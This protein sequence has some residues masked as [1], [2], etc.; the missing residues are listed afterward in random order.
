[1]ARLPHY[2]VTFSGILGTVSSPL[3]TWS[4]GL[5]TATPDGFGDFVPQAYADGCRDAYVAGIDPLMP[6]DVLLRQTRVA[7]IDDTGKYMV[8][9]DGAYMMA[10]NTSGAG[11]SGAPRAL[12]A[13]AALAVTLTTARS[14]P[15]GK[16]RIFLPFP[17]VPIDSGDK[18]I[19]VASADLVVNAVKT[20]INGI[21]NVAG[22]PG[23]VVA[24]SKGYHSPVTGIK[25]GRRPDVLRSRSRAQV[26]NYR[27]ASLP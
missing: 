5:R 9:P 10:N 26:E 17:A 6:T 27:I 2:L 16:G 12:P 18:L 19:S 22:L 1:M 3:E 7:A 15:T 8:G 14:G 23:V 21:N 11:G 24:S 20:L 13:S 25:V 4:F